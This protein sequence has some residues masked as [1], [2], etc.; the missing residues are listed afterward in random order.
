MRSAPTNDRYAAMASAN[1]STKPGA[2]IGSNPG[3]NQTPT[4]ARTLA[5]RSRRG[6]MRPTKRS[7]NSIGST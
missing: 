7:P 2:S 4:I 5:L 3:S 1:A 6:S